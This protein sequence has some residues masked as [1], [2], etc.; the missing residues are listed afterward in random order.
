MSCSSP[1]RMVVFPAPE[2]A[3]STKRMPVCRPLM[4][5]R[6]PD[7][8]RVQG[9]RDCFC[10]SYQIGGGNF[11]SAC[12]RSVAGHRYRSLQVLYLFPD[13]LVL[14]AQLDHQLSEARVLA[15][16]ADGVALAGHLLAEEVQ[17]PPD[18]VFLPEHPL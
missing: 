3:D 9:E 6:P 5:L 2:G 18:G 7:V 13:P 8:R 10:L 1:R 17:P 15:L 4:T 11:P 14:G 12:A 16:G